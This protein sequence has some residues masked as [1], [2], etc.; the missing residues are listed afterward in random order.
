MRLVEGSEAASSAERV[1][2][3]EM[4]RQLHEWERARAD[5]RAPAPAPA[6]APPSPCPEL[7]YEARSQVRVRR[8]PRRRAPAAPPSPPPSPTP[9]TGT[10]TRTRSRGTVHI[11]LWTLDSDE[12]GARR[13]VLR[14]GTLDAWLQPATNDTNK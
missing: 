4:R 9:G 14:N 11:N 3:G 5:L 2:L 8:A 7:T 6:P 12:G 10:G 13:R 1:A